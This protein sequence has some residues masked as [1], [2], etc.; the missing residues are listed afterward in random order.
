MA[1]KL[2]PGNLYF[3]RDIDYL[4]GEIS[5]YVKIGIVT[6]DRTTET[7]LKEHQTGNPRGIY[8][9]DE[10]VLVP[11]V[12]RLE[13]HIHYEFNE[14]WISGEWFLLS[15]KEIE[16]VVERA[17][18]IQAQQII[19]KPIIEN[20]LLKL[21]KSVS[22]GKMKKATKE[23]KDL[24]AQILILKAELNILDAK[25][26]ISKNSFYKLLGA[27]GSIDKVLNIKYT[28][29]SLKFDDKAF[30]AAHPA[31]YTKFTLPRDPS[32]KHTFSFT[33]I[34]STSLKTI[35]PTLHAAKSA[36]I[37]IK[38][39]KA[40]LKGVQ[41]RT[42]AIEKM[43]AEHLILMKDSKLK[44]FELEILEYRLQKLVGTYDGIDGICTWKRY[45]APQTDAFNASA[46]KEKHPN[47]Y[48]AFVTKPSSESFAMEVEKG[49]AYKPK[50]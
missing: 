18:E 4:T 50:K 15:D 13:T 30:A 2:T 44:E 22:N 38:C 3:I 11:F 48:E 23:A 26:E 37:K 5:K 45:Y 43:H 33:N 49:R 29:S 27:N 1:I 14:R 8:P 24:E 41:K 19:D 17:K 16:T 10:V 39:T 21:H 42:K 9:V 36:I 34:S 12:E 35:D 47:L 7:R 6:K 31:L 20:A 28:P 46:F 25:I 40:Q 32:F